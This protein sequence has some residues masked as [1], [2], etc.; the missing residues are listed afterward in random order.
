[1]TIENETFLTSLEEAKANA[2]EMAAQ[3]HKENQAHEKENSCKVVM[4]NY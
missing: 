1:L 4:C 2:L 3:A